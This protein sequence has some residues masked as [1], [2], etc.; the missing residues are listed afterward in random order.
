MPAP[1]TSAIFS[2]AADIQ[3]LE[4]FGTAANVTVDITTS[5]VSL[6]YVADGWNGNFIKEIRVKDAATSGSSAA[7]VVRFWLND[8]KHVATL[9]NAGDTVSI[10]A[11]G[12]ENGD[13]IRLTEFTGADELAAYVN[14]PL[15][16]VNKAANTF[17]VSA[18]SGGSAITWTVDGS[19]SIFYQIIQSKS[20]AWITTATSS[21]A[22][23]AL[24]GELGLP[25]VTY[26]ATTANQDFS[27]PCNFALPPSWRI[28]ATVGTVVGGNH[29]LTCTVMGG[30]Y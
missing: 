8:G 18:T 26:S 3:I 29:E 16:V 1:N 24:I 9:P 7:T 2:K 13:I 23:S 11:H 14:T 10:T 27:Y 4:S 12:L 30:K 17:Q 21:S 22:R 25:A 19:G 5:N 28:Y 6:L 20:R 15:Y